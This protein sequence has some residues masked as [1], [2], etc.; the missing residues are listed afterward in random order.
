MKRLRRSVVRSNAVERPARKVR[1][2]LGYV[3]LALLGMAAREGVAQE[4]RLSL[5]Q[6]KVDYGVL[7]RTELLDEQTSGRNIVL[8]KRTLQLS[9]LCA[10]PGT[11]ALRFTGAP[12]GAQGFRFGR[13]G[14]FTLALKNAQ[15]D[16]RA[17]ELSAAQPT[18]VSA[19]GLLLPGQVVIAKAG[20][21]PLA[22]KR[23]SAQVHIDTYLPPDAFSVRQ[24]TQ[25]E[26]QGHF[27]LLPG[28]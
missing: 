15:V 3:L 27:E 16:G 10:E 28:G 21:T 20:G 12:A 14:S 19:G 23:F 11:V 8:G 22:G 5:S 13:H 6:P 4:C 18:D 9:V 1:A 17:V 25:F 26:G 24:E 7:R 2:A